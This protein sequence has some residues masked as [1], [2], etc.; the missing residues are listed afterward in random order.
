VAG[1][2]ILARVLGGGLIAGAVFLY[3]LS[4]LLGPIPFAMIPFWVLGLLLVGV[5]THGR[6]A[7]HAVAV[8]EEAG[9]VEPITVWGKVAET[10]GQC[11]TGA[12]APRGAEFA[13]SQGDVWPHLCPHTRDAVLELVAKMEHGEAIPD[14]P[15]WYHDADHAFRIEPHKEPRPVDVEPR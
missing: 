1:A 9:A 4:L 7:Q 3:L 8:A 13:V 10:G 2:P 5:L 12:T 15:I 14:Y 11:P 6:E